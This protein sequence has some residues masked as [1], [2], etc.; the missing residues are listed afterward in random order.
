MTGI[1]VKLLLGLSLLF[2]SGFGMDTEKQYTKEENILKERCVDEVVAIF[3]REM[4]EKFGLFC[5]GDGGS[6]PNDIQSIEVMFVLH[7]QVTIEEARELQVKATDR[8]VEIINAQETIRPH[9]R[10]YP[11]DHTRADV[12][13]SF[14]DKT[15]R[16]YPEGVSYIFQAKQK[17]FYFGPEKYPNDIDHMKEEPYEEARRIV[18]TSPSCL[19]T[20]PKSI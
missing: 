15:G 10:E 9:L 6:M 19:K 18:Y 13:I 2:S 5:K 14:R 11:W 20:P 4:Q 12:T 17:M 8:L 3:Q 7:R 1:G 16:D